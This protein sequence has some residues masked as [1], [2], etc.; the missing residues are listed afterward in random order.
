MQLRETSETD[1]A[2]ILHLHCLAF[3]RNGGDEVAGLVEA[4]LS[5][6]SAAPRLSILATEAG[7]AVGHILFSTARLV[8]DSDSAKLALLSPLAVV[9]DAQNQGIGGKLI[10]RGLQQLKEAGTD[11][12]FVLGH[13]GYYRRH[14]FEPAGKLGFEAPFP[15]PDKD[16]DA[17]MI[18]ALRPGLIG[19]LRGKIVCCEALDAPEYWRE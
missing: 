2:D 3:G 8:E 17:W 16:A 4:I 11:L 6:P 5:D 14:G 19:S 9:P 1:L 7:Q 15:I 18:K 13:P 12:V 10:E